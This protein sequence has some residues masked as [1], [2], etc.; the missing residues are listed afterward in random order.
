MVNDTNDIILAN[1]DVHG[2]A[3]YT[4]HSTSAE[5]RTDKTATP[6]KP[7]PDN[8]TKEYAQTLAYWGNDTNNY[9]DKIIKLAY[10]NSII[11]SSL[12]FKARAIT[13]G[14]LYYSDPETDLDGD[15]TTPFVKHSEIEQFIKGNKLKTRYCTKLL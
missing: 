5:L 3:I 14:H 7:K 2:S 9:P 15:Q 4:M 1:I 13:A 12:D 8:I 10:Q 6:T 11:P